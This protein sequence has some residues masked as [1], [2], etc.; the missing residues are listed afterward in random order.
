MSVSSDTYD[1]VLG[2]TSLLVSDK[3]S[4][5]SL[6]ESNQKFNIYIYKYVHLKKNDMDP[7]II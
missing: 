6:L 1:R 4:L 2:A 5:S 7:H 3:A